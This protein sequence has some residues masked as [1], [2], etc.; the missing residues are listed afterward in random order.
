MARRGMMFRR[1]SRF[2]RDERA[3][4]AVMGAI[5]A[6]CG[7]GALAL[8]VDA[9]T[10]YFERRRAQGAVD[11]A[12]IA[13]ARDINRAEAAAAATIGDNAVPAV[14][15][16]VITRGR[17]TA[18][19]A[20]PAS[21]RFKANATPQNAVRVDLTNS[22]PLYFGRSLARSPSWE[23]FTQATAVNTAEAAFTIGSRLLSLNGGVLNAVLGSALGGNISLT[24]MDYNNLAGFNV[25][26]FKFSNALA[27][28]ASG[29]IGTYDQLA[30]ANVSAGNVLDALA[31]IAQ[32]TPGA[33]AA[34]LSLNTL[35]NQSNGA[36][37]KIPAG[38][39]ISFGPS[40]YL[41]IGQGGS[42]LSTK[43]S[44][45]SIVNAVA[46]IANGKNQAEVVSN[47]S[48]PGLASVQLGVTVGE[49]PQS[50]PWVAVGEEGASVYT[51]QTR[52][53]LN[54]TIGGSGILLG[55]SIKL[56]IYIDIASG[57][58][59][60]TSVNC[61]ANPETDIRVSLG[62][63]PAVINAW[64]GQASTNWTT[65][66][67]PA[68]MQPAAI[69]SVPLLGVSVTGK[70]Q[71]Q[72]TNMHPTNVDFSW[73]DIKNLNPKTVKTSDFTASLVSGLADNLSLSV[74]VGPLSLLTPA[75]VTAAVKTILM[76]LTPTLD[77]L[78]NDVLK[79]LGIGLGEADVWVNGVR[80]D[81]AALVN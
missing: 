54:V 64:I 18:D 28:K 76:P 6:V 77:A 72:M 70:A 49:R 66:T 13:A 19:A 61:G 24:A 45:L 58:A 9:I 44:A 74:S 80:C 41:G 2:V 63:T 4:I 35:K 68:S 33:S 14:Q 31:S 34:Q 52:V 11:L 56:P 22:A 46:G 27:T 65:L 42:A 7:I 73:S 57:K 53:R 71:V 8:G 25:D 15:T 38:Q 59:T 55:T 29:S 79:T 48:V 36:T 60:L 1:F 26:L 12:A 47:I 39:L 30:A 17:Y 32:A 40:G 67:L 37:V 78:V 75:V 20:T 43:A 69:A 5:I 62:V 51:A 10:L 16:I 81:G 23:V 3:S 21:L 50:S